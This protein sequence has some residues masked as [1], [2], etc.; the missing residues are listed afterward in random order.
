MCIFCDF[1]ETDIIVAKR[2][3]FLV[4]LVRQADKVKENSIIVISN[5]SSKLKDVVIV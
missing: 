1:S 5:T 2:H 4:A 3:W